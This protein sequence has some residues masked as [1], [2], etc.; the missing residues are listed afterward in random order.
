MAKTPSILV[1]VAGEYF[2]A[3]ELSRRGYIASVTL[4]N[5]KGVD[6][7]ASNQEATRQVGIQVKTNQYAKPEWILNEKADTYY[8][9]NLFY[10]FV[11][12]RDD[13]LRPD[14]YV[15][16]SKDVAQYARST[17]KEWLDAPGKKGQRHKDSPIRKFRDPEGRYLD[18]WGLLGI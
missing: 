4:R 13:R 15:V 11:N 12:L 3:G 5:S 2:V 18:K 7:L 17:H 10:V 1:G 16:P 6:I 9:D 14:F 8:A